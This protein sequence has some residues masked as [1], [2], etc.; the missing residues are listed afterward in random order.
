MDLESLST[1]TDRTKFE[2]SVQSASG[3]PRQRS[4]ARDL[5][6]DLPLSNPP[7]HCTR[8]KEILL[9]S[10]TLSLRRTL[11]QGFGSRVIPIGLKNR[12]SAADPEGALDIPDSAFDETDRRSPGQLDALWQDVV[13]IYEEAAECEEYN[14]DENAWGS[15]VIQSI[16][17]IG[18]KHHPILHVK[19]VQTQTIDPLL[20]PR[21]P[22]KTRVSRKID[23]AF[24]FSVRDQQI[25]NMYD[26]VA[27][28]LP[29]Q[30]ISHTTDPFTKRVAL[31]SGIEVK[32]S[33]GGK[34][35]ALAQL[36]IWLASGLEKLLE[37]SNLQ[38][39]DAEH[40]SLLPTLGWTVVGHDWHL[41]IAFRGIFEGQERIYI[42]GP[43]ESVAASTRS[44]YGIFKLMDLVHRAS[45][46][47]EEVYWPWMRD[48]ILS[49]VTR[50]D[51]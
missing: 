37:L 32:Q 34:M 30:T 5:L 46:Y 1:L 41:Y 39:K 19:N 48:E 9:P 40:S 25:K 27:I 6:N 17:K 10:S 29:N 44:Y 28:A 26:S 22:H 18:A 15:G 3:Q 49:P 45:M 31:F 33:N 4:P 50:I 12:I 23:Y 38:G 8:P 35:E 7:I 24:A 42:D 14:Q 47:A 16:L 43:I 36:A 2:P 51:S 20:L 13:E 21:L 11:C